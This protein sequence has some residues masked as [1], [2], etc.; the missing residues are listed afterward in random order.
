[1]ENQ[2][3]LF[4]AYKGSDPY[5]FV[6]YAHKD[7]ARVYPI[8]EY[9]HKKGFRIWY[10]EGIDPG[11]E[12]PDEIARA[13]E[14]CSFFMVLISK[15]SAAS[16]NV[17]NE[18]NFAIDENK[19]FLAIHM[20][21]TGLPPGIRLRVGST[22]AIMKYRLD[23]ET[24]FKKIDKVFMSKLPQIDG[25][26]D[27]DDRSEI[28][29][30]EKEPVPLPTFLSDE[31]G[32]LSGNLIS[33]GKF[34]HRG[35]WVYYSNF[36]GKLFRMRPDGSAR[37]KICDDSC[38]SINVV[39]DWIYYISYSGI[40]RIKT[41]GTRKELLLKELCSFIRVVDGTIYYGRYHSLLKRYQIYKMNLD[42]GSHV[43]ICGN[44]C[45]QLAVSEDSII[46]AKEPGPI[47]RK[48]AEFIDNAIYFDERSV[49]MK[50]YR[51]GMDGRNKE[52]LVSECYHFDVQDDW[53]YY[54]CIDGLNRVRLDGAYHSTLTGTS[55]DRFI[56]S[57]EWIYFTKNDFEIG[58]YRMRND[59]MQEVKLTEDT[60]C[61]L[62]IIDDSIYYLNEQE[63]TWYRI[64]TDGGERRPVF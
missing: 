7:L 38:E 9:L 56:I 18:I 49:C 3:N 13:L 6:S 51:I 57:G 59:G 21:E 32:N 4:E 46:Y 27:G 58:I 25:N 16:K 52:L 54:S 10:D 28:I 29:A 48:I 19:P 60:G 62:H 37:T 63:K 40:C 64:R 20:E 11:N 17:I 26:A 41:D 2:N 15:N 45:N 50:L 33:G 35:D 39:E 44:R 24:F 8:I 36:D 23:D 53:V 1:M 34:A 30:Q 42:G 47:A 43:K 14:K 55:C 61:F 5:A 22:Q 31:R 12:W